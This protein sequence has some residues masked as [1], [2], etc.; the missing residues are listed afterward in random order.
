LKLKS[1]FI[2]FNALVAFSFVFVFLM[3]AFFLGWDYTTVFWRANWYLA[4]LFVAVLA[5]LN[6]YFAHNWR[7]F[8]ALERE[9]WDRVIGVL[10]KRVFRKRRLTQGNVRLLVNAYVVTSR[11]DRI[12]DL[13]RYLRD[14]RPAVLEKCALLFGIPHLLSNDGDEMAEFYGE[15]VDRRRG[16]NNDWLR[17]SYAF[18]L[19]LKQRLPEAKEILEELCMRLKPGILLGLSAYLLDAYG[20]A[21]DD[22]Q[23]IVD[24]AKTRITESLSA[25]DWRKRVER[26]R[27]DLHVLVLTKL[28]RDVENWLYG[29]QAGQAASGGQS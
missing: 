4:L 6:A 12:R 7:L 13:E 1:I 15:F 21:E 29:E 22:S 27:T 11:S 23:R 18:A 10:E 25:S 3:P 16:R 24:T 5:I 28:L 17:W 19:M 26:E 14:H 8:N 9:D 2:V 20:S